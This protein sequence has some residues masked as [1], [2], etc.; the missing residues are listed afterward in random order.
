MVQITLH[1]GSDADW[2]GGGIREE[3]TSERGILGI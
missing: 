3:E 2:C 1:K